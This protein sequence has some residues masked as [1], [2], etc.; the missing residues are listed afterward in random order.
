MST[1]YS[2]AEQ[3]TG[4]SRITKLFALLLGFAVLCFGMVTGGAPAANA[5]GNT[6]TGVLQGKIS[7]PAGTDVSKYELWVEDI[8]GRA[9][10][11]TF[12]IA[13]DGSFKIEQ[14]ET[15]TYRLSA[16]E[17]GTV[18]APGGGTYDLSKQVLKTSAGSYKFTATNGQTT[19]QNFV[20]QPATAT[21]KGTADLKGYDRLLV[22]VMQLIDGQWVNLSVAYDSSGL[23]AKNFTSPKLAPGVYTLYFYVVSP[24]G[25]IG[26]FDC[27]MWLGNQN[28]WD[29]TTTRQITI[30]AGGSGSVTDANVAFPYIWDQRPVPTVTGT[31]QVGKPFTGDAGQSLPAPDSMSH[32]WYRTSSGPDGGGIAIEGAT[33]LTYTPTAADLGYSLQLNTVY[34]KA[35][36]N[37]LY[38]WSANSA[39]V[40]AGAIVAGT[41]TVSGTPKVGSKLTANVGTWTPSSVT[42]S[43]KW[44]RGASAISGATT[45]EYTPVAADNGQDISVQVTGALAGYTTASKTSG[46]VRV[47]AG[48][49]TAGTP[50]ITG[51]PKVGS[52]LTAGTGTWAPA[53]DS[54]TY[55]WLRG[56]VAISGA[57]SEKYTLAAADNGKDISVEVT[58][59]KAG[60]AN[61]SKTSATIRVGAG[62]MTAGTPTISGTAKVGS[63]LTAEPGTWTPAADS[64]TYKWLRGGTAIPGATSN[65][66]TATAADS[67]KELSVEVTGTKVGYANASKASVPKMIAAGTMTAG[68]PTITGTAKVGSQLTVGTG[69][70]SPVAEK[71]T[72]QWLRGTTAIPGATVNSYTLV[73][74]DSG[75]DISVKVT[76][77]KTG[78][79]TATGTSAKVNVAPG[80]LEA[81][82]PTIS[83]PA[84]V[85]ETLK[86]NTGTWKP[87]ADKYTYQWHRD[88][89]DIAGAT[90][91]SFVLT[92]GDKGAQI[93]VTVT[94]SKAGYSNASKT[95]AKTSKVEA[96]VYLPP[97]KSPFNDITPKDKFYK[98]IAWMYDTGLSTGT[99]G[100]YKPKD[101]VSRE[102]MAAFLYRMKNSTYKGPKVSPFDDVK[103][104]DKFYN[105][106]AWMYETKLSTG[107]KQPG[108]KPAYKPKDTVSREAMAAFIY[109]LEKATTPAPS[110]SPF[111]DMKK[112]DKFYKEIAWMGTEGL[113]TGNKQPSGKPFYAPKDTVTREAMAAFLY[114]LETN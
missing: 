95:S 76:G 77:T 70:W 90:T 46:K 42:Y 86:A 8:D 96:A 107:N 91:D 27:V 92:A 66:Y 26:G 56:G 73:G 103:P 108:K 3:R 57:T 31:P 2:L 93:S 112:G 6:G 29:E 45:K 41:P 54:Y 9:G 74:A 78:Y 88:G 21:I 33:G 61:A 68:T 51:T 11:G 16:I 43:Y 22:D 72:Y 89:K 19:N 85:G 111:A 37:D 63:Q 30:G 35:K 69:T 58:G 62:T 20:M 17:P 34:S 113:S 67:G 4:Q 81:G 80:T 1:N 10:M 13:P 97:T 110:V 59:V 48:S 44:F 7:L 71:Y 105:E 79:T 38:E 64:Y 82:T 23:S 75:Q 49:M 53:A 24:T 25:S 100:A 39:P 36:Y 52:E 50:T 47:A 99:K 40:T 109:R 12:P 28:C 106:I 83:G 94:G 15:G 5:I 84:T 60:F 14:L 55:K 101:G 104:G 102:A 65:K 87:A 18:P 32:Q 98:Q 114:R